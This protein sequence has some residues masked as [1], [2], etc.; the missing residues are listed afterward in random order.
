[1]TKTNPFLAMRQLQQAVKS[2]NKEQ[3]E[4]YA[5]VLIVALDDVRTMNLSAFKRKYLEKIDV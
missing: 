2:L 3:R 5:G 4:A 1:M